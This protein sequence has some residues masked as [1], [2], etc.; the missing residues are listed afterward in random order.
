MLQTRGKQTSIGRC[1][2]LGFE[3]EAESDHHASGKGFN[4][5]RPVKE[6]ERGQ[7]GDR[8]TGCFRKE[9]TQSYCSNIGFLRK[10]ALRCQGAI[11]G[12]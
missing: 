11:L 1:F 6:E 7:R 5:S 4:I 8:G 10:R 9:L 2:L 12:P 3:R